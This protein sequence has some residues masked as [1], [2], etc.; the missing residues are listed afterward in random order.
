VDSTAGNLPR[1]NVGRAPDP[2]SADAFADLIEQLRALQSSVGGARPSVTESRATA[3]LLAQAAELLD[4]SQTDEAG[5][6]SG[7]LVQVPGRAQALIPALLYERHEADYV[8]GTVTFGRFYHGGGGAVHGGG[9]PLV[10]DEILGRLA[11]DGGRP[12]SRTAYLHVNFRKITPLNRPLQFSGS[13][14][15]IEG[16]KLYLSGA[17]TDGEDLLA[18]AEGLFV[19]LKPGQP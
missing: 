9:I 7:T 14:D 13:V 6:I 8:S 15:K 12:R 17:L 19:F 5:Q 2:E 16:R 4:Q 10:F 18:D 3:A 1:W 11:G